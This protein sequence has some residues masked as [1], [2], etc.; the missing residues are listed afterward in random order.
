MEGFL[1]QV[2][3]LGPVAHGSVSEVRKP[4]T[5]SGCESCRS[6]RKHPVILFTYWI[7]GHQRCAYV[8]KELAAA[9]REAVK[10]G[11]KLEELI[12]Q[13]GVEYLAELKRVRREKQA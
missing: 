8:P 7:G 6:G 3:R 13:A 1:K 12:T 9:L 11:R 2:G 4:C 5:R 10:N